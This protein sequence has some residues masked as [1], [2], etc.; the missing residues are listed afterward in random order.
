MFREISVL[1]LATLACGCTTISPSSKTVVPECASGAMLIQYDSV[2]EGLLQ[3]RTKY[4]FEHDKGYRKI[5]DPDI[6][7]VLQKVCMSK[8]EVQDNNQ[9]A[10]GR[11]VNPRTKESMWVYS[12]GR[13]SVKGYLI[14]L[15][16]EDWQTLIE[17]L[18]ANTPSLD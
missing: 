5:D 12:D 1:L 8:S 15:S 4:E 7:R 6:R 17:A 9:R 13:V 3:P 16:E 18:E 14:Q 11:I 2:R 10:L